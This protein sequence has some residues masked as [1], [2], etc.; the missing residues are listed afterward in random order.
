[1]MDDD[2]EAA[3]LLRDPYVQETIE[4]ALAP[5]IGIASPDLLRS[6]RATL[7]E[8]MSTHPYAVGIIKQLRARRAPAATEEVPRGGERQDDEASGRG[9][10]S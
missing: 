5:Y 2:D 7:E 9:S 1:M 6:M 8:A 10:R 3:E 4:R